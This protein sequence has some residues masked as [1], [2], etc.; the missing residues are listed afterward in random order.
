MWTPQL[1]ATLGSA[2]VT[3]GLWLLWGDAPIPLLAAVALGVAGALAWGCASIGAVW[4]WTTLLLGLES[5]AFPVVT[6]VQIRM[7]TAEPSQEQME[8]MLTAILFGVF[9]SIFWLTFS[10]GIFKKLRSRAEGEKG[11][12]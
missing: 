1:N 10:Y 3:I 6:M 12:G 9:S 5:F 2:V 8:Q 4:A 11:R 7:A